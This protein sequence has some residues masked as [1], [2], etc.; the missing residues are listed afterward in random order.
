MCLN[1][2][3]GI[4]VPSSHFCDVRLGQQPTLRIFQVLLQL[5]GLRWVEVTAKSAKKPG[6]LGWLQK[7]SVFR[8]HPESSAV[9]RSFSFWEA[10]L[11]QKLAMF[12]TNHIMLKNLQFCYTLSANKRPLNGLF[13]SHLKLQ[14]DGP[15]KDL[16]SG[17]YYLWL[18]NL[19]NSCNTLHENHSGK[20]G[21][22][23]TCIY[24]YIYQCSKR[25]GNWM[26]HWYNITIKAI[27]SMDKCSAKMIP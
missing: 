9:L 23:S 1:K 21:R 19:I 20:S 5:I 14:N 6:R 27:M 25:N 16:R 4:S 3:G 17:Q 13:A 22:Q 8:W 10:S 11:V 26:I 12:N 18:Q 2:S 7:P 15:G 24:I